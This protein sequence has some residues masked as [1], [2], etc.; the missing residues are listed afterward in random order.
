MCWRIAAQS[1]AIGTQ[2]SH[3]EVGSTGRF[4]G[5][6]EYALEGT[7]GHEL[8]PLSVLFPGL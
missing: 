8:I 7:V 6:Q 2:K 3:Q 5:Q 4:S 1:D